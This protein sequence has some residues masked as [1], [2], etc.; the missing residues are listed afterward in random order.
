MKTIARPFPWLSILGLLLLLLPGL[1]R[2]AA[3]G[4][5]RFTPFGPMDGRFESLV[6]DPHLPTSLL[7]TVDQ[8]GVFRSDDAG[9]TWAWSGIGLGTALPQ[10]LAADA[11]NPGVF[12]AISASQ[13]F[14]SDD[15]GRHW[16]TVASG[17][18]F[19]MPF[20]ENSLDDFYSPQL[21]VLPAAAGEP[22]T[23]LAGAG[24]RL[25][26]SSDGGATWSTVYTAVKP[27]TGWSLAVDPADPERVWA[28]L[29][30]SEGAGGVLASADAG[31]TWTLLAGY[32]DPI[33]EGAAALIVLPAPPGQPAT[34][35]AASGSYYVEPA[36]FKSTDSGLTWRPV[37]YSTR[38]GPVT[39]LAY[40]PQTPS[41]L[42]A[43]SGSSLFVSADAGETWQQRGGGIDV[44]IGFFNL[45]AVP[46]TRT[47]Y[48]VS[49]NDLL[50]SADRGRHW[51]I[52]TQSGRDISALFHFLPGDPATI[53]LVLGG[54][55]FKSTNGG[56]TWA[57]FAAQ[58]I[59]GQRLL[60][61]DVAIDPGDPR[62]VYLATQI[63]I[64]RTTD[65][66]TTWSPLAQIQGLTHLQLVGRK[67]TFAADCG[68]LR[69]TDGGETWKRT[70]SC[71]PTLPDSEGRGVNR[72]LL[73]PH[74]PG[75]VYAQVVELFGRQPPQEAFQIWKSADGG[76]TWKRIVPDGFAIALD[77]NR[78]GRLYVSRTAGIEQSDDGG[79]TFRVLQPNFRPNDLLVDP[80]ASPK[81]PLTLYAA[82]GQDGVFSSTNG[83]VTWQPINA[84]L[85]R[86]VSSP[87]YV[88]GIVLNPAEPHLL[89][90]RVNSWILQNQITEP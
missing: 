86:Y 67:L 60:A 11:G 53:Y 59:A 33:Q 9:R 52:A 72:L 57:S 49:M 1:A 81:T 51:S 54:V 80:L 36:L 18:D 38:N 48:G 37:A 82:S 68:V 76:V 30:A 90:A 42:Y 85:R 66:G 7:A 34:L 13:A 84:G 22:A 73:A 83:G 79:R 74:E 25:E 78:A 2:P 87:W 47:V 15:G 44:E 45:V 61:L 89:Y 28:G 12:Y 24:Q 29:F 70:L 50:V 14:R 77:P 23:L 20:V 56:A 8:N 75:V 35:L 26:R 21:T 43:A 19:T 16:A 41:F 17:Q 71:A 58:I 3:A 27:E 39:A 69:S 63:G 32:P 10:A 31:K 64:F 88:D 65:G 46:G 5:D 55:V 6:V 62:I 4:I 40:E